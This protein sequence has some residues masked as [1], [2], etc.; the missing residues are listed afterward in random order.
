[1]TY[2]V[3]PTMI[4]QTKISP[5]LSFSLN[6]PEERNQISAIVHM[7]I[8]TTPY[9]GLLIFFM[10]NIY[11]EQHHEVNISYC[12]KCAIDDILHVYKMIFGE[13]IDSEFPF[14]KC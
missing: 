3:A 9:Q 4:I 12:D 14:H 6:I 1:M 2:S 13:R 11:Q 7:I 5:I 10:R 8:Q